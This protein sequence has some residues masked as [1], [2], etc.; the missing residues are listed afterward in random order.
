VTSVAVDHWLLKYIND[1]L[2]WPWVVI[3]GRDSWLSALLCSSLVQVH[4]A[5]NDLW[6]S[7]FLTTVS[8]YI[9]CHSRCMF[10]KTIRLTLYEMTWIRLCIHLAAE[11]RVCSLSARFLLVL[12]SFHITDIISA[13]VCL[14]SL[15]NNS[16]SVQLCLLSLEI[17]LRM[18]LLG[19]TAG[20]V[21]YHCLFFVP[22][23]PTNPLLVLTHSLLVC[24][25]GLVMAVAAGLVFGLNFT[26]V[27]YIQQHPDQYPGASSNGD[28]SIRPSLWSL[29]HSCRL[30]FV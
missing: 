23:A 11:R 17:H 14:G 19:F 29:I 9:Q 26:P 28:V 1:D 3:E 27:I 8:L 22:C 20:G 18:S 21:I 6:V 12:V 5:A 25:S 7:S 2:E 16:G 30:V 13:T 4:L 24:Y 10:W 15:C